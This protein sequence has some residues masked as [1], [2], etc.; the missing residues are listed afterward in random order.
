LTTET[1]ISKPP[2]EDTERP[3]RQ[4]PPSLWVRLLLLG[5]GWFL[6]LVGVA[7]LVLP[8]IQGILTMLLGAAIL[9]IASETV[10][11]LLRRLLRQRFPGLWRKLNGFRER[12]RQ[13]LARRR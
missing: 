7:G 11:R 13:R 5:L 9:S 4:P 10:Y 8:G 2:G 3:R 6:L 1:P 12:W